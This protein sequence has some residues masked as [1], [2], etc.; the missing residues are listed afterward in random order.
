MPSFPQLSNELAIRGVA[1]APQ[2]KAT[3]Y[4]GG[5]FSITELRGLG[6]QALVT[7][8]PSGTSIGTDIG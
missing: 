8:T 6:S 7:I 1:I 3:Q 2:Q 5:F 4:S